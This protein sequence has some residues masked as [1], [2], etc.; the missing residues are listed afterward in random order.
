MEEEMSSKGNKGSKSNG[1]VTPKWNNPDW[2][3]GAVIVSLFGTFLLLISLLSK[4]QFVVMH[5]TVVL[6]QGI[7]APAVLMG[8]IVWAIVEFFTPPGKSIEDL[9]VRIIPAFII[10]AF[11]GGLLGYMYNF[12]D[13]V[14]N[15]AF[16][17]SAD[18]LLFLVSVLVAGLA[19]VWNA[20]WS[21][22]HGFRGQKGKGSKVLTKSE[23]GTSKG[24]RGMLA[25]LIIF[26]VAILIVPIGAGLGNLFVTGHDNT[27]ILA[28]ESSTVYITGS[29]GPIPFG[30]VNGTATFDFPSTTSNNTTTYYHTVYLETNLTLAELNNFAVSKLV[31]STSDSGNVNVTMGT[32]N[33][34]DFVPIVTANAVNG[35][36]VQL[37]I[38][39]QL[40]TGNQSAP[41]TMEITA[42]VTSMSVSIQ[43]LGNNGLVTV[44]GPYPVMQ[45][46]YLLGAVLL[47]AS[48]F[49]EISVYD[50][51][52]HAFGSAPV[53]GGKKA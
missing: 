5:H 40:L 18:A 3:L 24:G 12:G 2:S 32:G 38:S 52:I 49:L 46:S 17:G 26:I 4:P 8:A 1:K 10:G 21:H 19:I 28:N 41:V 44:F 34:T 35:S 51:D 30:Q 23:S 20:A 9:L 6:T 37:G 27:H 29:S 13:Y 15:P 11:F 42:N 7:V 22:K 25:L 36:S 14:I 31:L 16:N 33:M 45:V 39:P 43:T 48:A 53:K 50:I 47:F